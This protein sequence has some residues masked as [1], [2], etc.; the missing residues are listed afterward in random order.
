MEALRS[1]KSE[2]HSLLSS[3]GESS[4]FIR[5]FW[6]GNPRLHFIIVHGALEHSGRHQDLVNFWMK[7]YPDVAVTIFD[8]VG[9]GRSG[10]PRAFVNS[11]KTYVD[12]LLKVAH[13]AQ[14]K[15]THE[16]KTFIC[17]HSLGGLITLT[18][19]L[20]SAYGWDLPL[21]GVIFSSPC[22]RAKN[23]FGIS[24][25]SLVE[26]LDRFLPNLHLPMIYRGHDLTRDVERANDFDTDPLIPKFLTVRMAKEILQACHKVRGLSYYLKYPNLFLVAGHDCLV[27]PESTVLFAHGIDKKYTTILQY[28]E[29]HHELW[30]ETN[31][32]EIFETMRKWVDK[33]LKEKT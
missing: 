33:L 21:A 25:D 26:K 14:E 27:D 18:R 15:L 31:R 20:D 22:I 4:L 32:L 8:N 17:A 2:D 12:D 28:P 16:T 7:T 29:D 6:R 10:G 24:A 13:F 3:D 9:H 23:A 5:R 30:N 11:F 1:S 19:L